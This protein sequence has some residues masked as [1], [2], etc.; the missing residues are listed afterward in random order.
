MGHEQIGG[1]ILQLCLP[2]KVIGAPVDTGS[3]DST[4]LI[5]GVIG[6][7]FPAKSNN[8]S[9]NNIKNNAINNTY[10]CLYIC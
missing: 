7:V 9:I 1:R 5:V 4:K 3:V 6:T 10:M 2:C 8:K